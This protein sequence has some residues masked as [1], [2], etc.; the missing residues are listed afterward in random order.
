VGQIRRANSAIA[1]TNRFAF[2]FYTKE[3]FIDLRRKANELAKAAGHTTLLQ[4]YE[5]WRAEHE[6][7]DTMEVRL[8]YCMRLLKQN[9]EENPFR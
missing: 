6:A 3:Y 8:R 7:P 9:P 5:Q 2:E 4:E 1:K